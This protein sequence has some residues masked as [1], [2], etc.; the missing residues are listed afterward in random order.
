[1]EAVLAEALPEIIEAGHVARAGETVRQGGNL[2]M[3]G[4]KV[5]REVLRQSRR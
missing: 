1:M 4:A 3:Q 5:A 2:R